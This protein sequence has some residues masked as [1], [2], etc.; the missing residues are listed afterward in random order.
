MKKYLK[1]KSNYNTNKVLILLL[2]L[3]VT[4][5]S[6]SQIIVKEFEPKK[7]GKKVYRITQPAPP[8]IF[9]P[10]TIDSVEETLSFFGKARPGATVTFMI[11]PIST[12]GSN[13]T[14]LVAGG[15]QNPYEMQTY[16]VV[17]NDRGGWSVRGVNVKFREGAKNRKIEILMAQKIGDKS[18]KLTALNFPIKD[19]PNVVIIKKF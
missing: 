18:S 4:W 11:T 1:S 3:L 9:L 8:T 16:E 15:S 14:V 6:Q 10:K 5:T 19:D 12:G 2:L 7:E 13:K 17:A